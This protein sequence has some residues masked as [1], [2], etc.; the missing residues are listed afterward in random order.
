MRTL[1]LAALVLGVLL[2][3]AAVSPWAASAAARVVGH[4]F[5]FARVFDRVFEGLLVVTLLLAWRPLD[6]GRPA[7]LGLARAGWGRALGRGLALGAAGLAVGLALCAL[8]GG[9]VATLRFAAA[10]TVRKAALGLAAAL[11]VAAG[12]ETLFRG[13]LL[14]RVTR[15]GGAVLGVAVTTVVYAAVHV[16]RTGGVSGRGGAWAGVARLEALFV[17]LA[18]PAAWPPLV[19]LGLL[20][21]LLAAARRRTGSLWT[22]I[23]IHAAWVALFRVGRLFFALASR[24]AWLVGTGWP[25][26]VGGAAAWLAVGVSAW[27]LRGSRWRARASG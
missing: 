22:P 10:K 2:A 20:G 9:V 25:P 18:A 16:V 6:L 8:G 19:G 1:G 24:P 27:L 21:I 26:F 17:P 4:P 7:E 12:E 14:R 23:G 5:T 3:A 11:A 13:V 15:D